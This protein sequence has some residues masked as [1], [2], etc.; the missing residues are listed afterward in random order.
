MLMTQYSLL[1]LWLR[2]FLYNFLS[3]YSSLPLR[4]PGTAP[5]RLALPWFCRLHRYSHMKASLKDCRVLRGHPGPSSRRGGVRPL[6]HRQEIIELPGGHRLSEQG[7]NPERPGGIVDEVGRLAPARHHRQHLSG[8]SHPARAGHRS[9]M[10]LHAGS[11]GGE[12][13]HPLLFPHAERPRWRRGLIGRSMGVE[14]FEHDDVTQPAR[15]ELISG[16]VEDVAIGELVPAVLPAH[17]SVEQAQAPGSALPAE[18]RL[19]RRS[20]LRAAGV[21][22][23]TVLAANPPSQHQDGFPVDGCTRISHG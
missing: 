14:G 4:C 13:D 11:D 2:L 12:L 8:G 17:P 19:E 20:Y 1:V 16:G 18:L 21:V 3:K 7:A 15:L 9:V 10:P 23:A 6:V 5:A 22:G